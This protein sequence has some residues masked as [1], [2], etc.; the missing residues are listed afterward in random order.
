MENKADQNKVTELTKIIREKDDYI[1]Q[2]EK[3]NAVYSQ[4]NLI[5]NQEIIDAEQIIVAH[6]NLHDFMTQEKKDYHI[7]IDAQEKIQ[8]VLIEENQDAQ[9]IIK[10]QESVHELS[11]LEKQ[12]AF[13]TIDAYEK[14]HELSLEEKKD[15]EA[16]I[17]AYEN[18][19]DLM[20]SEKKEANNV[21]KAYETIQG[22]AEKEM[23]IKDMAIEKI[24]E[25]NQ[26]I[27]SIL[28]KDKLLHKILHHLINV[29]N[30]NR[31]IIFLFE[32]NA[33]VS[34]ILINFN[35]TEVAKDYFNYSQAIIKQSIKEK[36]TIFINNHPIKINGNDTNIS[37]VSSPLIYRNN[38]LGVTYA[39]IIEPS[40][41][42]NKKHITIIDIFSSQAAISLNNTLLYESLKRQIVTDILTGLPNRRK[43]E[44]DLKQYS[45]QDFFILCNIDKFSFINVVHGQETGDFV[46]KEFAQ[47]LKMTLPGST[48]IYRLAGDEFVIIGD[49]KNIS[50]K[51]ILNQL[52]ILISNI[53]IQYNKERIN[54]SF[55]IGVVD[56]EETNILKKA[57]L[58]LKAAKNKNSGTIVIYSKE[59]DFESYYQNIFKFKNIIKTALIEDSIM[60]YYQGIYNNQSQK[61]EIY[62][63]LA[64]ISKDEEL[65][66]PDDF[67]NAAK[68]TGLYNY[69]TF[70]I[71][72]KSFYQFR[73]KPVMF[74]INLSREDL[75]NSELIEFLNYQ[76]V[77]N[78]ID[79][80]QVIIE[81]L[82]SI[83]LDEYPEA[84]EVLQSL[85]ARGFKIAIDDFGAGYSN[86]SRLLS[87]EVDFIK[88]HGSFIKNIDQDQNSYE[89]TKSITELAHSIG[90]RVIAEYVH[91][92]E[93]QRI[94]LDFGIEYSQGFLFSKPAAHINVPSQLS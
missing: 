2:L 71:I 14:L 59:M 39:D 74:S 35:E 86:L 54:I 60:P 94:L 7:I 68:L 58:A 76:L 64:R 89:I 82:E 21:I 1:K 37:L 22:L 11:I 69:I 19:Y 13:E 25:I 61:I 72:D 5:S 27:N 44:I 30:F 84:F 80:N 73:D 34:K 51:L 24:L 36:K 17:E 67:I 15:F 33:F 43:L 65:F 92:Q 49:S 87:M 75:Q 88:I 23:M 81:V 12:D 63:C 83:S 53:D 57:D 70:T 38:I 29:L 52:K 26:S 47:K 18:V 45:K 55:S 6:E 28:E 85:K 41:V 42:F 78:K 48:S 4:T 77:K 9:D 93:I 20:L 40:F 90:T 79:P 46:L 62:E 91:K 10:A 66:Y 3:M 50:L 8:D 56:N 16:T 32:R 31:G